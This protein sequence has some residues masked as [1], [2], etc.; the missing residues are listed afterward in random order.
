MWIR[1]GKNKN[2]EHSL[3]KF[4]VNVHLEERR[5]VDDDDENNNN[6]NNNNNNMGPVTVGWEDCEWTKLACDFF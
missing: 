1:F 2:L 3:G 5:R 6:N 4:F